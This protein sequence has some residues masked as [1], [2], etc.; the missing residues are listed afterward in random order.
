MLLGHTDVVHARGWRE[1]WAGTERED[2]FGA[3]DRRRRDLGPRRR[4]SQGRHRHRPSRR[5]AC[6]TAPG[7][8]SATSCTAFIGDEESGE[9][10]T[11]VS[12][13]MKALAAAIDCRRACRAP[14]SPIYVEPTTLDVYPAQ[15]GF[16]IADITVTGPHRLFR[17]ARARRRRAQGDPRHPLRALGPFRRD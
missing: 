10:G 7:F 17:H 13:G 3:A 12:A 16:F 9:P 11:G 2:P 14:I 15:M 8:G 5:S 6:S 4:R 1:R